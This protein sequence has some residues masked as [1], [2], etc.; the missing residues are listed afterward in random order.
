MGLVEFIG[1]RLSAS[2]ESDDFVVQER[3]SLGWVEW[4]RG[5][6]VILGVD[7][8]KTLKDQVGLKGCQVKRRE[9]GRYLV[10]LK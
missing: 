8:L 3:T 5:G 4:G 2:L 10:N 7:Q 6:G 1:S 9:D